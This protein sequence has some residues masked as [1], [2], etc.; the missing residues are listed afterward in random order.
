ML[1]LDETTQ[2]DSLRSWRERLQ[3]RLDQAPEDAKSWY[4]LGHVEL[5]LSQPNAAAQAFAKTDALIENDVSVKFYWL[6]ARL[7]ASNG[8]LDSVSEG[9]RISF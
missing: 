8:Q 4:L 3:Q 1:T 9:W 5:K 7:L 6:Q 2:S